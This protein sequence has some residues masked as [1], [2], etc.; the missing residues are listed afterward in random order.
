MSRVRR[1]AHDMC[2]KPLNARSS[3]LLAQGH[4]LH[5]GAADGAVDFALAAS[6]SQSA[7]HTVS[8]TSSAV[9]ASDDCASPD[10]PASCGIAVE[11]AADCAR[12]ATGG[13]D[14]DSDAGYA[15]AEDWPASPASVGQAPAGMASPKP[16]RS[17]AR[18][19]I[20]SPAA[21]AVDAAVTPS[22]GHVYAY[23]GALAGVAVA[24]TLNHWMLSRMR[25]TYRPGRWVAS[26]S[27][28]CLMW[29]WSA[30]LC[31]IR[32]GHGSETIDACDREKMQVIGHWRPSP[33]LPMSCVSTVAMPRCRRLSS[34]WTT[35]LS[36][37]APLQRR[38]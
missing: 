20:G 36:L 3:H 27:T 1:L 5:A 23:D 30:R 14:S 34:A 7:Q 24:S 18:P 17:V 16:L 28:C 8:E 10:G 15:S 21:E 31:A 38:R 4:W 2:C 6:T 26:L 19:C 33:N 22:D 35:A 29:W 11:A 37:R 32:Q 13:W 9:G 12:D 25:V